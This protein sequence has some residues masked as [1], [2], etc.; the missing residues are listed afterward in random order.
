M[1]LPHLLVGIWQRRAAHLFFVLT[2]SAVIGI[3][4]AELVL[5]HARSIDQFAEALR[6][7]HVPIFVLTVS[8]VGFVHFYFGTGRIWLGIA[9]CLVR[10]AA[11]VINFIFSPALNF[12]EITGLRAVPFLGETVSTPIGVMSPWTHLGELSSLLLLVYVVDASIALRR[13]GNSEKRQRAII[14][15]G[16]IALFILLATGGTALIHRQII[17]IPYLVSFPFAAI[18]VAMALELSLDLFRLGEVAQKLQSSE[19]SLEESR[20][21]F[22]RMADAAPVLIWMSGQDKLCTFFNTA[23][24]NFTGRNLEEEVGNGW[25]AGVHPEDVAKCLATYSAAFEA[26]EPFVMQYRL[27]NHKGEHRWLTNHGVPRYDAKK[28]FLGYVG[29]CVDITDLLTKERALHEFEE[30]VALAAEAAHLGVWELDTS[31]NEVWMSDKARE[32]FEFE[33]DTAISYL[34]FQDRLHP[35]DRSMRDAAIRKAI[36]SKGA[37][38]IEY[39]TILS[40]GTVRW[41]GGRGRCVS[42]DGEPLRLLGVSMDVTERKEAQEL[43]ELA[44]EASPGGTVLV[45][46]QGHI[47]LVNAHVQRFFGYG[48]EELIGKSIETLVPEPFLTGYQLSRANFE[49]RSMGPDR[50]LFARRKDGT[51]FPVEI[52]LNP[53]QAPRGLLILVSVT[54]ISARK[55]AEEEAR[56]QRE[57][58]DLLSRVSLLGEMTASLA[59][60]LNQPLSAIMSNANAGIRF[61]DRGDFNEEELRDILVDVVADG[62]RAHDIIANVRNTIK[63][64]S[65][66]REPISVN[67]VVTHVARLVQSDALGHSCRIETSLGDNLPIVEGD[68]TQIQQV[69]INL[70]GNAFDAMHHMPVNE[71]KVEL[72]TERNG[73]KTIKVSVRDYGAGISDETRK[74]LFEKFYTTK[75]EGLGMGLAIVRSIVESHGGRIDVE[76]ANGGGAKF[77]FTLPA[78]MEN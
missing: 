20:A 8:L 32:L 59:H 73:D 65:A 53:I 66:I 25:T 14:V 33:A 48:R 39:R 60:E 77:Y 22:R 19:A 74:R 24:L 43:F 71:R 68:P 3:A 76:N 78:N 2:A 18:L 10:S 11:L 45:D 61:I 26:R 46:S 51:E 67:K 57:E 21:R 29:A 70:M 12:R 56:R 75:E 1:A 13:Q 63:K 31:T 62:R 54:D 41:I 35:D 36:E 30:R 6:W 49:P 50:E 28:K 42:N 40:N 15:G 23:W 72:T 9:V 47:L 69:L 27:R 52:R 38:E 55:R 34:A 4:Y 5:M 58:I 64:G 7:I 16:S 44:T 37:Y 17:A